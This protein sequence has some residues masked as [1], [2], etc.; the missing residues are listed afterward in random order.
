MKET[1]YIEIDTDNRTVKIIAPDPASTAV[2]ALRNLIIEGA[3]NVVGY[4]DIRVE[5]L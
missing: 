1:L 5:K 2:E 3:I 4:D